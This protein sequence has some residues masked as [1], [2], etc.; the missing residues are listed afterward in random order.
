M[1]TH[2]HRHMN[3]IHYISFNV[4]QEQTDSEIKVT[5]VGNETHNVQDNDVIGTVSI[6]CLTC[7]H[8]CWTYFTRVACSF[9]RLYRTFIV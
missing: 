4:E 7:I 8:T 5:C 2:G 9:V 3:N 6:R 1:R